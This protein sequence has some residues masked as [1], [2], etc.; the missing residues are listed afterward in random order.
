MTSP[1]IEKLL[2]PAHRLAALVFTDI[3]DSTLL[4]AKL[5]SAYF[6]LLERHNELFEAGIRESPGAEIIKHTGDG[7]FASFA[8]ASDAVHFALLFQA[9]MKLEPWSPEKIECRV[10][11]HIGEVLMMDMA[12]RKD[13][14]GLSA[15][16]A[17][18]LMSLAV[19]GQILLTDTAFNDARQFVDSS[20]SI[21]ADAPPLRWMAH[22]KY[23]V[24]GTDE[25]LEVYEVGVENVFP[26]RPPVD[27]D[28]VKRVVPH[29]QE[30]MLGWRPAMS[31]SV[32][33]RPG[34]QLVRKLGEGGFGEVW[35]GEHRRLKEL[36][37]FKFCFD[38]DRLRGLK[39]EYM[40]F[41][42]LREALGRRSDIAAL[43]EVK[44]DEPPYFLES[45]Y[46]EGGSLLEWAEH[47]GGI[48]SLS[49]A[50]RVE[51]L[52]KVADALA[53][54]HS[55]GII[56][57]DIKPANI[58]INESS[59]GR[60]TPQ[61]ADFGISFILDRSNLKAHNVTDAGFTEMVSASKTSLGTRMYLPPENTRDTVFTMRGDIYALGVIL[62]Q[63]VVGDLQRPLGT[64]WERDVSDPVM[65]GDIAAVVD[66]DPERRM[67]SA[68]EVARMLRSQD[69]RRAEIEKARQE[70]IAHAHRQK[71]RRATA[72]VAA[73]IIILFAIGYVTDEVH[74]HN[75]NIQRDAAVA[76]ADALRAEQA[77]TMAATQFLLG[78][79]REANPATAENGNPTAQTLIFNASGSL[80]SAFADDSEISGDVQMCFADALRNFG[81]SRP[82]YDHYAKAYATYRKFD[83]DSSRKALQALDG[84]GAALLKDYRTY[85]QA[86]AVLKDVW[87]KQAKALGP[88]DRD[89]L[90]S[91]L[92]YAAAIYNVDGPIAAEPWF[93]DALNRRRQNFHEDDRDTIQSISAYGMV[94]RDLGRLQ[95]AHLLLKQAM[96]WRIAH[97]GPDHFSTLP[98]LFNYGLLLIDLG[99]PGESVPLLKTLVDRRVQ[100]DPTQSKTDVLRAFA[101]YADALAATGDYAQAEGYYKKALDG[102]HA[103]DQTVRVRQKD[104]AAAECG[105]AELLTATGR[106]PAA[107]PLAQEAFDALR[108]NPA[109]GPM[110]IVRAEFAWTIA[111]LSVPPTLASYQD[112]L[113][114]PLASGKAEARQY[115]SGYTPS[116]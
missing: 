83:G 34:W 24:K 69:A 32:P 17:S 98:S 9:R 40:L 85:P 18:R 47:R 88:D 29:D 82:A 7:Y 53:A 3:V 2:T 19:G 49:M 89:T 91:E 97:F 116:P 108:S 6:P 109:V 22:G 104:A 75:L 50:D 23:L 68:T 11:I 5:R 86:L 38:T 114:A 65:R 76:A 21:L 42:L 55:V 95:D 31:L 1:N 4:Q 30:S 62:Y 103:R 112:V 115:V 100:L 101:A 48:K 37:V 105:Y 111:M 8:T 74:V 94:E 93:K 66:G 106:A 87:D 84:Q 57:K 35:L 20:P 96:D 27:S 92:F 79:I 10:G 43:Y 54:A 90:A 25:P 71:T 110:L 16:I 60:I 78:V 72:L 12:G 56:H 73:A 113:S 59:D 45:E 77:R 63:F 13:V 15:D 44:L 64:G 70:A 107:A 102:F 80:D 28:K 99:R 67:G 33:G 46:T 26:L 52:A 58:L 39:R 36:R 61:L 14:V 81:D 41:R 51:I